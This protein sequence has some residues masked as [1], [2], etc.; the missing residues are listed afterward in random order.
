MKNIFEPLLKLL[1]E[2]PGRIFGAV[3]PLVLVILLLTGLFYLT[4][5]DVLS[6]QTVPAMLIDTTA[7]ADLTT[8]EGKETPPVDITKISKPD[9]LII[10][11]GKALFSANCTSCHGEAGNGDGPAGS[12]L[13]PKPRNFHLTEGWKNG[14]KIVDIYKTLQLGVTGSGMSAYDYLPP[15]DRFAL[16]HYVRTFIAAPPL[17]T[18]AEL[19]ALD[20]TYSLSKGSKIAGQIPTKTAYNL[21]LSENKQNYEFIAETINKIAS[22]KTE[23]AVIF[24]KVSKNKNKALNTLNNSKLWHQNQQ[25]F[26]NLLAEN[27]P[28]NGFNGNVHTLT[29]EE[30]ASLQNYLRNYFKD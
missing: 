28:V 25:E 26:V 2:N 30:I 10:S 3:Y 23:G 20:N 14:R 7:I 17:D 1:N 13:N 21:V 22:D 24:N 12:A 15:A 5:V 8:S 27:I 19:A 29:T 6:R 4:K 16:I 11:K 18:P 9:S